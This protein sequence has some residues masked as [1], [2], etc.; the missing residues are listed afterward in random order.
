MAAKKSTFDAFQ[1]YYEIMVDWDRRLEREAPFF[2]RVFQSVHARRV[3]DC[4]CGTGRH[5]CLFARWGLEVTGSDVSDEMLRKSR[6]LAATENLEIPFYRASFDE[7]AATFEAPF[8]AVVCVGNS[9]SAAGKRSTVAEGIRQMHQRL[10]PDGALLIQVLNYERFT[11]GET[12]YREPVHREQIG[13]HYLFLKAFRRAGTTCDMDIIV[14]ADGATSTW[15]RTV[16]R[17]RLLV[18]DR[19][20]LVDMVTQAGFGKLKLYGGYQ[21]TPYN[22][23]TSRDLIVVARRE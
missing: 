20:A 12:V 11:P 3:L 13:Q 9:L 18:L 5:A 15:T 17:E 16:F 10:A 22:P 4:A 6:H 7:L 1:P 21:M 14:L 19:S 2:Q 8:D 23:R